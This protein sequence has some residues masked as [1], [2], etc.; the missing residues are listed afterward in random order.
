[1]GDA[2]GDMDAI[3]TCAGWYFQPEGRCGC[4]EGESDRMMY[5][6]LEWKSGSGSD[7]E[8]FPVSW[9]SHQLCAFDLGVNRRNVTLPAP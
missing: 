7:V 2:Y 4:T 9:M 8:C 1:M 5:G 3:K 6:W